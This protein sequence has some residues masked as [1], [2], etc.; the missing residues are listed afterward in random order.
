MLQRRV[1]SITLNHYQG[2][3]INNDVAL[4]RLTEPVPIEPN[5]VPICLPEG[6]DSY[7]GREVIRE[8]RFSGCRYSKPQAHIRLQLVTS[9]ELYLHRQ[10]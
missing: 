8:H 9:F 10:C 2:A 6:S 4:L 1:E 5:L 7:V 3:R